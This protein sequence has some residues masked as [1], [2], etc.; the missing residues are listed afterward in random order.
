MRLSKERGGDSAED[1]N[2]AHRG[3]VRECAVV[4]AGAA[5]GGSIATRTDDTVNMNSQHHDI[6]G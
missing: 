4:V 6:D 5:S 3:D 1:T 2:D